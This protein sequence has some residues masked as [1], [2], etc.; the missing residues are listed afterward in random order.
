MWTEQLE[1]TCKAARDGSRRV[2][3]YVYEDASLERIGSSHNALCD[4]ANLRTHDD[5]LFVRTLLSM[6]FRQDV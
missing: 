2:S 4:T 1:R 5:A 6:C 3:L